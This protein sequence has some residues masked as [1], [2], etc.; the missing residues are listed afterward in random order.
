MRRVPSERGFPFT[1]GFLTEQI[2]PLLLFPMSSVRKSK[3]E[4]HL[5]PVQNVRPVFMTAAQI[6]NFRPLTTAAGSFDAIPEHFCTQ[7]PQVLV[8][9]VINPAAAVGWHPRTGGEQSAQPGP[10][11]KMTANFT[12]QHFVVLL[13]QTGFQL[14]AVKSQPGQAVTFQ[15][16]LHSLV[17]L[18]KIQ[19]ASM[20]AINKYVG[21]RLSI[22]PLCPVGN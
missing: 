7:N 16:H 3:A 18:Y 5:F 21:V 19:S 2:R 15:L 10:T 14:C 12:T 8:Y 20:R 6:R 17:Y 4:N 9:V 1:V 11:L 13:Y 22:T